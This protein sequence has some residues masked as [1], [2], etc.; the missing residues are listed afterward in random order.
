M[1]SVREE[2]VASGQLDTPNNCW[3]TFINKCRDNIHICLCFPQSGDDLGRQCTN[4]IDS[5]SSIVI[6]CFDSW[7]EEAL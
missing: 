1:D 7:P 6:D 5:V 4:F 2:V 3:R